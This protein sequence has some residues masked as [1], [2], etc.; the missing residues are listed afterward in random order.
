MN[1][2]H[3]ALLASRESWRCVQAHD[4]QGWLDLM[5]EDVCIEDP[6]GVAPT[7]P[8]GKGLSGK[9]VVAEF[10][11]ANIAKNELSIECHQSYLSASPLEAAHVLT[12]TNKFPNGVQGVVTGVFTYRVNEAGKLVSLRG[13][14]DMDAMTLS[15]PES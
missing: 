4:K 11:E 15:Q 7:N 10:Y 6:I 2:E 13:Y 3:P 1:E 8:E 12:L 14:W 9:A 5:A